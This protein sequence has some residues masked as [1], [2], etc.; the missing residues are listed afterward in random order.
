L[1]ALS[2]Y[3]YLSVVAAVP[4]DPFNRRQA[5]PEAAVSGGLRGLS[6]RTSAFGDKSPRYINSYA[7]DQQ[8]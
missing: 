8:V 4:V 5:R 1:S 3:I 7:V 2:F 6:P